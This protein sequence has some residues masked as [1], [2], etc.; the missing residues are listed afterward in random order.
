MHI[1]CEHLQKD[2]HLPNAVQRED[3][4]SKHHCLSLASSFALWQTKFRKYFRRGKSLEWTSRIAECSES[5]SLIYS[6]RPWFIILSENG[7]VC[8]Q[9]T[10][11]FHFDYNSWSAIVYRKFILRFSI[12]RKNV[13]Q[14]QPI[15]DDHLC[16]SA[17]QRP[18]MVV[19]WS[20]TPKLPNMAEGT[21]LHQTKYRRRNIKI[22]PKTLQKW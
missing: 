1:L 3:G 13:I 7:V 11:R 10:T 14:F 9:Y 6:L 22:D 17:N 8:S 18:I 16:S 20:H 5:R 21:F 4:L 19:S 2:I 12:C 15:R